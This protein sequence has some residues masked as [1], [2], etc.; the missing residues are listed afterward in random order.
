MYIIIYIFVIFNG[1]NPESVLCSVLSL[2]PRE[3]L[4]ETLKSYMMQVTSQKYSHP[5][6]LYILKF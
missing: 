2:G 6:Y 3:E 5:F 1:I 4:L